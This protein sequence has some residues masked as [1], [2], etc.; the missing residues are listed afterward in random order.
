MNFEIRYISVKFQIRYITIKTIT[1]ELTSKLLLLFILYDHKEVIQLLIPKSHFHQK[2]RYV[3]L[4]CHQL[5]KSLQYIKYN[6][7]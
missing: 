3:I 1:R 4:P 5:S 6:Y 2:S 7:I